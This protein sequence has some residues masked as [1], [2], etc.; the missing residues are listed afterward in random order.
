[1]NRFDCDQCGAN[2]PCKM[3]GSDN[4]CT[5]YP[6]RPNVCVGFRAGDEQCQ[7]ARRMAV[8]SELLP[9]DVAARPV[10]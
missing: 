8:L 1:M 2:M 9:V 7:G 6:T 4:R 10:V 3:L 5:V